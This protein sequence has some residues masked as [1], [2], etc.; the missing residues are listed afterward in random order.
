MYQVART[1]D[2]PSIHRASWP[3]AAD[4]AALR[5]VEGGGAIFDAAAGF[6]E[7]VHRAKSQAGASVGRHLARLRVA[8][9]PGTV[10]LFA[11]VKD[12]A[13]AAAR[14]EEHA[15]EGRDGLEDGAFEVLECE[16]AAVRPE[17]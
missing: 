15:V 4:F 14:V 6:L 1:E 8:A 3:G 13:V 5:P 17:A 7:A 12:D 9:S 11:G 2:A 10:R 16:L